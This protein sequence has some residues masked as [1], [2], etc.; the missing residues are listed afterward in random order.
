MPVGESVKEKIKMGALSEMVVQVQ[1]LE[2]REKMVKH[3][4]KLLSTISVIAK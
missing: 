3:V 1:V 4:L 2:E